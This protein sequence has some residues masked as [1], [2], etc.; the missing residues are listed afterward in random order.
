VSSSPIELTLP[1]G[2]TYTLVYEGDV[3][4]V[5]D[6]LALRRLVAQVL[7]AIEPGALAPLAEALGHA[8][9]PDDRE[10]SAAWLT[11]VL[12]R[13]DLVA[14]ELDAPPVGVHVVSDVDEVVDDWSA[15][16][17]LHELRDPAAAPQIWVEFRVV[18]GAGRPFARA[19]VRLHYADRPPAVV[20]LDA[21]GFHRIESASA[22]APVRVELPARAELP[23]WRERGAA[24]PTAASDLVLRGAPGAVVQLPQPRARYRILVAEPPPGFSA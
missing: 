22:A 12:R 3:A 18:D 19:A 11:D 16:V 21:A 5:D 8:P 17:P 23:P 20:Q 1:D 10:A 14:L 2:R 4:R 13:G 9:T 15:A 6:D 24:I 7:D